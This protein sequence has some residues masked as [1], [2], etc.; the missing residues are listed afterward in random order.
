MEN[1]KHK[2]YRAQENAFVALR[3]D[4]K[5]TGRISDISTNGLSF[6]YL[7]KNSNADT[8]KDTLFAD[9]FLSRNRFHLPHLPCTI[10]YEIS[11][12]S[13]IKINGAEM[14]RCGLE[15]KDLNRHQIERLNVFIKN[16]TIGIVV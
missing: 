14:F 15:F 6:S 7:A 4:F 10:V 2:R 11:D 1:R 9:I 12:F 16:Y 13:A 8:H 5:K 3:I